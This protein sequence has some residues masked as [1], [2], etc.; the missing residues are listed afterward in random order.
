MQQIDK[1]LRIKEETK[2]VI[3]HLNDNGNY[4]IH[5]YDVVEREKGSHTATIGWY[6]VDVTKG[7]M[8]E[9]Y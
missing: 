5:V 6:K 7:T 8:E 9:Y 3:D 4:V 1:S 2:V